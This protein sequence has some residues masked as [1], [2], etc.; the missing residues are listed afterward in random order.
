MKSNHHMILEAK[1][2]RSFLKKSFSSEWDILISFNFNIA[3]YP[4]SSKLIRE[5]YFL[6]YNLLA[7]YLSYQHIAITLLHQTEDAA[8]DYTIVGCRTVHCGQE[9]KNITEQFEQEQVLDRL[10]DVDVWAN[11]ENI[12]SGKSKKCLLC[13][14]TAIFCMRNKTHSYEALRVATDTK[15]MYWLQDEAKKYHGNVLKKE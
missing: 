11:G 12:S 2:K 10:L 5:A 7:Q 13:D 4:K 14:S 1:E 8:G 6:A 15:I 3:G 9:V